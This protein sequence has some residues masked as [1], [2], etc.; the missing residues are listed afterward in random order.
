MVLREIRYWK[1]FWLLRFKYIVEQ[2]FKIISNSLTGKQQ[3]LKSSRKNPFS[4]K[5]SHIRSLLYGEWR[6]YSK[7]CSW[8][9]Q[10]LWILYYVKLP[11]TNFENLKTCKQN[12]SEKERLKLNW[13]KHLLVQKE[14]KQTLWK[15]EGKMYLGFLDFNF[16]CETCSSGKYIANIAFS[17][18]ALLCLVQLQ[19]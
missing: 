5:F 10:S 16:L 13:F 18:D 9:L 19:C 11:I 1:G 4:P 3:F 8:Q 17:L 6:T 7:L 12:N 14:S 2:P 15:N